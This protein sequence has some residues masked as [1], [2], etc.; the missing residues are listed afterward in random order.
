MWLKKDKIKGFELRQIGHLLEL[1]GS[2]SIGN[3]GNVEG[4]EEADEAKLMYKRHLHE[5][6][7]GWDVNRSSKDPARED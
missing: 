6:L 7:L 2:L 5:L 4:R 3:L 1:R